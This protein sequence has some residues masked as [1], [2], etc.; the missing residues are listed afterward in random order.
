MFLSVA[1]IPGTGRAWASLKQ[2]SV[3]SVGIQA[4][5]F[6]EERRQIWATKRDRGCVSSSLSCRG[7]VVLFVKVTTG[8]ACSGAVQ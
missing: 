4:I 3:L 2:Q 8:V 6:L 1:F 5:F 7:T